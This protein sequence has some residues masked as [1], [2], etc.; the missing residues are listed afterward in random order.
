M[1][2]KATLVHPDKVRLW[3]SVDETIRPLRSDAALIERGAWH[4]GLCQIYAWS[5]L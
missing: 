1:S 2:R 5:E 3:L 4:G